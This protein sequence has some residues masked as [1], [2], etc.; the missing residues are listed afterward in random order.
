MV[1]FYF[2]HN[3]Q[4]MIFYLFDSSRWLFSTLLLYLFNPY[5]QTIF[6]LLNL[7]TIKWPE[8]LNCLNMLSYQ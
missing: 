5:H 1:F 7:K 6:T 2:S 3:L 8:L 4:V